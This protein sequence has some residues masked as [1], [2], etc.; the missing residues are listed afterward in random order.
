MKNKIKI[1]AWV[2]LEADVL[3]C[4][5]LNNTEKV[6]YAFISALSNNSDK[7]CF[8]TNKYLSLVLNISEREV[9]YCLSKLKEL[10]LIEINLKECNKRT[11]T[12]TVNAFLEYRKEKTKELREVER[13]I[14]EYDWLTDFEN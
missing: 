12:T 5:K 6:L 2:A 3:I 1:P 4:N 7:K 14:L 13:E 11:I 9:Q 8:A 10:N